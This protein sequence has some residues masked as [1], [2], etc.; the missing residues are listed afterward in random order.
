MNTRW[1]LELGVLLIA[2]GFAAA[3]ETPAPRRGPAVVGGV[4]GPER[5]AALPPLHGELVKSLAVRPEFQGASAVD[6]G[7]AAAYAKLNEPPGWRIDVQTVAFG[8]T[9]NLV[10]FAYAADNMTV[11]AAARRPC[12]VGQKGRRDWYDPGP[13]QLVENAIRELASDIGRGWTKLPAV[14][15]AKRV[16]VLVVPWKVTAAEA[17]GGSVDAMIKDGAG[18]TGPKLEPAPMLDVGGLQPLTIAAVSAAG[19]QP[20]IGQGGAEPGPEVAMS[21]KVEVARAA[22]DFAFRYT[23]AQGGKTVQRQVRRVAKA[24]LYETLAAGARAMFLG[25]GAVRDVVRLAQGPAE[26]VAITTGKDARLV[27]NSPEGLRAVD[28]ETGEDAWKIEHSRR[29]ALAVCVGDPAGPMVFRF[30]G[31]GSRVDLATGKVTPVTA[32]APGAAWSLA[33]NAE[34]DAVAVVSGPVLTVFREG[35]EAWKFTSPEAISAG[36]LLCGD[37]LIIGTEGGDLLALNLAD[38]KELWRR[39]IASQPRGS[40]ANIGELILVG[41]VDGKVFAIMPAD[42][43][44]TWTHQAGDVLVGVPKITSRGLFLADKTNTIWL[45]DATSGKPRASWTASTWLTHAQVVEV[46][47]VTRIVTADRRGVLRWHSLDDLRP[48]R[49]VTLC[50]SPVHLTPRLLVAG[51]LPESLGARDDFAKKSPALLAGDSE[52]NVYVVSLPD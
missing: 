26:L 17:S 24:S 42:G 6:P 52:G 9:R 11:V 2:C 49:E 15:A 12:R 27:L 19:Y 4:L 3:A 37:R 35:K 29:Q 20:V 18:S 7:S 46:G 22:D 36:P 21:F 28:V 1:K 38:G 47:G 51:E 23:L 13:N 34:G 40:I 39:A 8:E 50:S 25:G 32:A 14:D 31:S 30:D 44:T 43:S 33:A 48:K 5:E 16:G 45:L 10:A 41:S